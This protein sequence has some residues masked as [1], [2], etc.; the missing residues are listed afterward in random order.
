MHRL[1]VHTVTFLKSVDSAAC[2]NQLL[3]T[4]VKRMTCGTNFYTDILL[5]RTRFDHVAA[6]AFDLRIFVIRMNSLL[7]CTFTSFNHTYQICH[8]KPAIVGYAHLF[9]NIQPPTASARITPKHG[10]NRCFYGRRSASVKY[11]NTTKP[12]NQHFFIIILS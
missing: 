1:F 6:S 12:K 4:C 3:L 9:Y 8:T 10:S 7:H 5:G 11:Y 2:V